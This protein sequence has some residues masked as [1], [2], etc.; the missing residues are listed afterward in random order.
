MHVAVH[1]AY[2]GPVGGSWARNLRENDKVK[3]ALNLAH[4]AGI[5][6]AIGLLFKID[7]SQPRGILDGIGYVAVIALTSPFGKRALLITATVISILIAVA[8]FLVPDRGISLAGMWANRAFAIC[9]VWTVV[10]VMW[11]RIELEDRI[12]RRE[13]SIHR[14]QAALSAIVRHCLLTDIPL[15]ERLAFICRIGAQALECGL[16]VITQR[17]ESEDTATILQSWRKPPW[18]NSLQPGAVLKEDP[19]LKTRLQA[20]LVVAIADIERSDATQERRRLARDLGIRA[21]LASEIYHGAPRSGMLFFA[22]DDAYAWN[23][24]ETAFARAVSNLVALLLSAQATADTLAALEMTNDGI[25]TEDAEGNV[26]YANRAARLLARPRKAGLTYPRPRAPLRGQH[27]RSDIQLEGRELEVHRSRLP[28]GGLITRL[29]DVTERNR[30]VTERAKLEDRLRQAAKMEAIGQLASGVA[31][32]FNN[33]LG[34]ITGFAGFIAEDQALDTVNRDFAQRI[35]AAS[36]RGKQ[37]VEQIMTFGEDRGVSL[38]TVDLGRTVRNSEALLA[39]AMPPGARLDVNCRDEE[40]LL[41]RGNEVQIGQL[42][43]NLVTNGRDALKAGE[44]WVR[45]EAMRAP[46]QEIEALRR[47]ADN[48][49]ERRVG[50]L[51]SDCA[52]ARLSIQD[53][54]AGIPAEIMDRVF[55]PFFSTKNRQRGTGLGLAV[56]HGVIRAHAGFCHL[57]S[58]VGAGTQFDIYLPLLAEEAAAASASSIRW[59]A[60]RVLIV[61]DDEDMADMLSIGLERLGFQTVTVQDPQLALAAIREDPCAFDALLTDQIMPGMH[62]TELIREARLVAPGLRTIICTAYVEH[63]AEPGKL[64]FVA[65]AVVHKPVEIQ[66]VA[67]AIAATQPEE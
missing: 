54:G 12:R 13:T 2:E 44:G 20:E 6:L 46:P 22:R 27:D 36:K 41:V 57:R 47:C 67:E 1:R 66:T 26:E 3:R 45:I 28:T 29:A 14:H 19:C 24:E 38:E 40:P 49:D 33:L 9:S 63:A 48:P 23:E 17:N 8:A 55:E 15:D 52:Y 25:F 16:V 50:L 21:M 7:V 59:A 31:H 39:E 64:M 58:T 53:S 35:L 56:V 61:D 37:M 18:P 51:R 30:A 60:C 42:I 10:L 65:D 34:A 62:G 11:Q 32:D 43:T 4:G 5:V